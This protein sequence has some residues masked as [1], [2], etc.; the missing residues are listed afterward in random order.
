[1]FYWLDRCLASPYMDMLFWLDTSSAI[2][3]TYLEDTWTAWMVH[4]IDSCTSLDHMGQ[5][6]QD[7]AHES[8][9]SWNDFWTK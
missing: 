3:L 6:P 8:S 7:T 5:L 1:M 4:Y 9:D 2:A